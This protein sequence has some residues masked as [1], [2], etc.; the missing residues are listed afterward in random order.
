MIL[1]QILKSL[2]VENI[3]NIVGKSKRLVHVK[4]ERLKVML[5]IIFIVMIDFAQNVIIPGQIDKLV[6]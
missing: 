4:K 5:N 6:E 3:K 2:G 1:I